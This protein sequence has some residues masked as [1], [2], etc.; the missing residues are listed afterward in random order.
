MQEVKLFSEREVLTGLVEDKIRLHS[1]ATEYYYETT[2][3]ELRELEEKKVKGSI[4]SRAEKAPF[5]TISK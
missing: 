4:V 5:D 1:K 2:F 3:E